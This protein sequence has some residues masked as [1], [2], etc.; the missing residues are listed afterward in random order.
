MKKEMEIRIERYKKYR[1]LVPMTADEVKGYTAPKSDKHVLDCNYKKILFGEEDAG[2]FVEKGDTEHK[3]WRNKVVEIIFSG[4]IPP[5]SVIKASGTDIYGDISEEKDGSIIGWA[6]SVNNG[7]EY[8]LHIDGDG[9]IYA[10]VHSGGLFSRFYQVKKIEFGNV[11]DTQD[12]EAMCDM[13]WDC[14]HLEELDVSKFNT[15]KV[16]D[17]KGM[18]WDCE[19][20][21]A[22]DVSGLSTSKVVDMSFMFASCRKLEKLDL[23]SFR[24]SKVTNMTFMFASCEKLETLDLSTFRTANVKN[25]Y[26]MFKGCS[27]LKTLD[28]SGF[29]TGKVSNMN[30]MFCDCKN[31]KTVD[32]SGF[33]MEKVKDQADMFKGCDCLNTGLTEDLSEEKSS[34]EKSLLADESLGRQPLSAD[35]KQREKSLLADESLGRQPLPADEKQREKSLLADESLGRQPL[36]MEESQREKAQKGETPKQK[37]TLDKNYKK[38]LFGENTEE[39]VNKIVEIVFSYDLELDST[40]DPFMLPA[41]VIEEEQWWFEELDFSKDLSEEQDHSIIGRLDELWGP[42]DTTYIL[43]INVNGEI[44]A[45]VDCGKLFADFTQVKN[46]EFN[47]LFD[48]SRV[49]NMRKMFSGCTRLSTVDVSGFNTQ[50]VTD[51]SAMFFGCETLR[52]LYISEFCTENVTDMADMFWNCKNLKALDVSKFD[53]G[54][55]TRMENMFADCQYIESLDVSGFDTKNVTNMNSMFKNCRNLKKVDVS[56]FNTQNVTDKEDMFYGCG[57]LSIFERRTD[58]KGFFGTLKSWFKG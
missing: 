31:L 21:K 53:T 14:S 30:S 46:I 47:N 7:K 50:N 12:A 15:K 27:N 18:F 38:I 10:P 57:Y 5:D 9:K 42:E 2:I 48:T 8:I 35:E 11:F 22:L 3:Y 58:K 17:M 56:G 1:T 25:M 39:W 23:S 16:R 32:I 26:S 36:L 44:Y 49:I 19:N 51:M 55:V 40:V 28:V 37:S 6:E 24:T 52:R 33:N 45:P 4:S 34:E 54:K 41:P 43:H 20:L 29:N 13:F